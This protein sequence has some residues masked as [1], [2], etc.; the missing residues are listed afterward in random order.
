VYF[1]ALATDYDGTIARYGSVSAD[2]CEALRRFK[3]SGRRLLLVT[4]RDLA[5]LR[6]AFSELAIFDRVILENGAVIYDPVKDEERAIAPAPPAHF[7]EKLI[8]RKVEP[9]SVGRSIIAT[10][11]PHEA[12]VL[13]VIRELGLELQIIFNK[14]AVMVL[15]AGV[16][17]ASG[18]GVA[19]AELDVS[20]HNVVAVGDAENDHAFLHAC[21]CSAAVA[22]ALPAIRQEADIV[23]SGD[24]GQGVQELVGRIIEDDARIVPPSRNGLFL[25]TSRSGEAIHLRPV[26]NVLIAGDS[27]SG[28]SGFATLLTER[29]ADK[30]LEFCVIDPEGDYDGLEHAA[31]IGSGTAAPVV[32]DAVKLLGDA[33]IN[34]VVNA[35]AASM[36]ER[37][38]LTAELLLPIGD[39]RA[40]TGRPHWLLIDEAH[41][42]LPATDTQRSW[43]LPETLPATVFI[44]VDPASLFEEA[45]R[46]IDLVLAFGERAT[47]T[48]AAFAAALGI[49]PPSEIPVAESDECLV[50]DRSSDQPPTLMKTE[51]ARQQHM[52]HAG[53]YAAGDVG[54]WKSFYFRGRRHEANL[55]A[56]NLMEFLEIAETVSDEIWEHHLRAGNY[57]AWFRHVIRDE[58]LARDAAEIEMDRN[59]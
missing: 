13:A 21:G 20:P 1:L 59:L 6:H 52:R 42:I 15:P 53:K 4:G 22:N 8:E 41:H 29:M 35:V 25:G 31:T 46:S 18:L 11:E 2:T 17:K 19:L 34:V 44:T 58:E 24:H 43:H 12:A 37:R 48:I 32:D 7:V 9:I 54:E 40:K 55:R 50:W 5:D 23:L 38:R 57:S 3:A 27:G 33:G 45:L 49:A 28:K 10:W 16:N 39:L 26:G 51:R 36:P 14:G 56:R 30:R 47:G